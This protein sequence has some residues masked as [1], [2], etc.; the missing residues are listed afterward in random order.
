MKLKYKCALCS[1][2]Y[3]LCGFTNHIQRT[4]KIKYKDYYDAYIDSEKH[5]CKYCGKPCAFANHRGYYDTCN[6][7]ICVRK[8]QHETML[9]RYGKSHRSADKIKTKP[10]IEYAF[11][12]QL[13]EH[14]FKNHA[15][16]NRH[17]IKKHSEITT[18]KYFLKYMN[19]ETK[20]CEICGKPAKWLGTHYHNVCGRPECTH[21]LRSKNNAMNDASIRKKISDVQKNFSAEKRRKIQQKKEMTCLAR[22]SVKHN[23][24]NKDIR[25]K[26][27]KTMEERYG[28]RC[29]VFTPNAIKTVHERYGVDH[30]SHSPEFAKNR[31]KKYY[32]D[33]IGFDSKDE[34]YLYNFMHA[35][36]ML[37]IAHPNHKLNYVHD[38]IEHTY[39]PDFL[40]NGKLYEVK[41]LHFFKDKNPSET[42]INPFDRT[43]DALYEAKHQCMI[44]N[45]VRILTDT[46]LF[47]LIKEFYNIE[48][49]ENIIFEKCF[50]KPF[51][52]TSKWP[53]EHPIWDSFL[54]GHVSPKDAWHDEKRFKAAI[55]NLIWMLNKSIDENK[56]IPFSRKHIRALLNID[57]SDEILY[58]ILNRFTIAK[59][60][61]KVT[62]LDETV[63]FKIIQEV[64]ADLSSGVYCPMAGFGGIVRGA[65]RWFDTHG[66]VA[67]VE[68]Y[69]INK[70]FCDWYG[71]TQR[72]VLA[73]TITTDKTVIV[74]P[75]FGK[76]YEHWKGTPDEMSDIGFLE[77]TKLIREHIKAP[78]YI[79]IGPENNKGKNS[80]G[81]F[82]RTVGVAYYP[83]TELDKLYDGGDK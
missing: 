56:Y 81:L 11:V 51:P 76:T 12:C 22:F 79:F 9:A 27:L 67:D 69:D 30:F 68:A 18:E 57:T 74:C 71:W 16:L 39:E 1:A 44:E 15:M 29:G 73:Q 77:W 75:P 40:I 55:K 3:N 38:N 20:F 60:A 4:H 53:A 14:G 26:G 19:G 66:L 33:G 24:Q 28:T 17:L 65:K 78:N 61:P 13:C 23:W 80:C 49:D 54:P 52:G 63:L 72:D 50:G 59:I 31:T 70:T 32:Q 2:E 34:I 21:A 35:T 83:T 25:E 62:A 8:R 37:V 47:G 42:M 48:L 58:L 64:G 5:V 7:D 43:Q 46:T 82:K 45:D 10:T 36:D 41:G 6:S